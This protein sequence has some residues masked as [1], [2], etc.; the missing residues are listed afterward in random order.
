MRFRDADRFFY[1]SI[2]FNEELIQKI[3][4]IADIVS[5]NV[6]LADVI[7]R[8]TD[9]KRSELGTKASVFQT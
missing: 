8:N 5:D 3:P 2:E 7:A 6:R 4:V 9:V 1:T